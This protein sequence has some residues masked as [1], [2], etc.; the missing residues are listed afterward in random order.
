[1]PKKTKAHKEAEAQ[2]ERMVELKMK[3]Q[4]RYYR[5]RGQTMALV[6]EIDREIADHIE[7]QV[8]NKKSEEK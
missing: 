4:R 6:A 3:W 5:L 1:M 2:A 7:A 8:Q